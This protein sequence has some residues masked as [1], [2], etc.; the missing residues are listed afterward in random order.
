MKSKI[1]YIGTLLVLLTASSLSAQEELPKDWNTEKIKGIRF[2]PYDHYQGNSYLTENFV[3]G[4]VVLDG[5]I[6][7]AN[8]NLRYCEYR[9]ELLYYN[10]EILTQINIDKISIKSFSLT[11]ENGVVRIFRQQFYNG[12]IP[13]NRF[14]ELLCDGDV[15]LLVYR[16]VVLQDCP[17]YYDET[18]GLKNMSFQNAFSYYLYNSKKGYEPIALD[19]KS[20]LSKFR[21]SDQGQVRKILRENKIR[22]K[23]E[24]SF[25]KA[26]KLLS[27]N[28]ILPV[29]GSKP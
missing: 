11:D 23:D 7:I 26:W 27:S 19:K 25:V 10:A 2:I 1:L 3:P 22:L 20:L 15:A 14:F 8:L 16:K 12:F 9:D 4:V 24:D 28:N 5:G 17:V 6:K 18:R 13:G 21:E 29:F